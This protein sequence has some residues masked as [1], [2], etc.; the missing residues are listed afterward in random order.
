MGLSVI[1]A[2]KKGAVGY[3][4]QSLTWQRLSRDGLN[5]KAVGLIL[6]VMTKVNVFLGLFL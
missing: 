3:N 5:C 2:V 1:D 4:L 6:L